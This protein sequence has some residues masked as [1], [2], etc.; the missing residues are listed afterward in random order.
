MHL[1]PLPKLTY[2]STSTMKPEK[3]GFFSS[4]FNYKASQ[5]RQVQECDGTPGAPGDAFTCMLQAISYSEDQIL[6]VFVFSQLYEWVL[7]LYHY[8]S[9]FKLDTGFREVLIGYCLG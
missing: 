5:F 7:Y 6:N 8:R 1:T 9:Y 3:T 2:A 4:F